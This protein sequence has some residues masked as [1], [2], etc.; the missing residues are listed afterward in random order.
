MPMDIERLRALLAV[1]DADEMQL[2]RIATDAVVALLGDHGSCVLTDHQPRIVYSTKLHLPDAVPIDLGRHPEITAALGGGA[3]LAVERAEM[4]SCVVVPLGAGSAKLGVLIAESV[5]SR[6]ASAEAL[7]TAGII[8]QTAARLLELARLRPAKMPVKPR[9]RMPTPILVSPRVSRKAAAD[10]TELRSRARRI[11]IVDDDPEMAKMTA[12]SLKAE[13]YRTE[14]ANSG[15]ECLTRA[16]TGSPD[17]VILDVMMPGADGFAVAQKLSE[18]P[19]TAQVPVVFL[20]GTADLTDRFR[21]LKLAAADFLAKPFSRAELVARVAL[22]LR[23]LD[24]RRELVSDANIDYP[25]GLGNVRQLQKQ[26]RIEQARSERYGTSLALLMIDVDRLK[27]FNDEHG[28]LAGTEL[29]AM[30]GDVL[31][32]EIRDTDVAARYGGDEFV[33]LLPHATLLDGVNFA[34]RTLARVRQCRLAGFSFSVSIGVSA[35]VAASDL[36][37][38]RLFEEADTAAFDA[39]RLGGD[40]VCGFNRSAE[41]LG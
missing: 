11:L 13:G 24:A 9:D 18:D 33:V 14:V 15:A 27:R 34:E 41:A 1:E 8:G 10:S 38:S 21:G 20:S 25:T 26:L 30:V 40:R 7:A 31:L 5:A 17:L 4:R 6:P 19:L 16:R 37:L 2:L 39:K 32:E 28:H 3:P 29:L 12:A 35:S 22:S 36:L 23:Q